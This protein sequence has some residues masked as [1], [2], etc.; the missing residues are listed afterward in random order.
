MI[1]YISLPE[2]FWLAEQVTGIDAATLAQAGRTDL[3]DS[4][5]RAGEAEF[6]GTGFYPGTAEKAAVLVC[7]SHGTIRFRT[8]TSARRGLR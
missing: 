3:A 8:E 1:R 6:G 4:A 2:F 7:D 5:L